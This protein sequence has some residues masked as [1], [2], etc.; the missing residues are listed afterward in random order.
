MV[1][2][3]L[4]T[5][6]RNQGLNII[7]VLGLN[8]INTNRLFF[9]KSI[10]S[11]SRYTRARCHGLIRPW[12]VSLGEEPAY[13]IEVISKFFNKMSYEDKT[14]LLIHELL[15]IPRTFSGA[16]RN[17]WV[18]GKELVG[19]RI[20]NKLYN[21]FIHNEKLNIN[22]SYFNSRVNYSF[23][24]E[25]SFFVNKVSKL[26]P[27]INPTNIHSLMI[28]NSVMRAPLMIM[29]LPRIWQLALNVD[30]NYLLVSTKAFNE[31]SVELKIKWVI[32]WLLLIP[33]SFSG[34]L[35]NK[36]ILMSEVNNIYESL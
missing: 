4:S 18:M 35:L 6:L 31:L 9:V 10:N 16:L 36:R 12:Q 11:T 1:K 27:H 28:N 25:L 8:Y 29:P 2:Y 33:K 24:N 21:K 23:N 22:K 32:R 30:A 7:N 13:I 26:M 17:H 34:S 5:D 20:V 14:K 19:K 3:E 15:H